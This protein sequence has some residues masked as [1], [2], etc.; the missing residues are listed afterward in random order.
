M[1]AWFY[2]N[3]LALNPDKMDTIVFGTYRI[4]QSAAAM[5]NVNVTGVLVK[6]SDAIKLLGATLDSNLILTG[7][8]NAVCKAT[9][10]HTRAL[11][12]I[13]RVLTEDTAKTG[14]CALVG[15]V[16]RA[17]I[18][19]G[20]YETLCTWGCSEH[21]DVLKNCQTL[22]LELFR[23]R[24]E[25]KIFV[26]T[27]LKQFVWWQ[28]CFTAPSLVLQHSQTTEPASWLDFNQITFGRQ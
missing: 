4:S 2:T 7:R 9:F 17:T 19:R 11:W 18:R 25:A 27:S 22:Q 13:R 26:E 21:Q 6:P 14:A 15:I 5:I 16:A 3:G 1:N 20:N 8:V 28:Y 23:G 12:Y 10:F 24:T